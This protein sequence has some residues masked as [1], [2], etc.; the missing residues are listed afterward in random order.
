[1][2]NQDN[3]NTLRD[4]DRYIECVPFDDLVVFDEGEEE[5]YIGRTSLNRFIL[6]PSIAGEIVTSLING[7]NL[8]VISEELNQRNIEV[9]L[10][11]YVENLI[12]LNFIKTVDGVEYESELIPKKNGLT[13]KFIKQKHVKWIFSKPI[14]IAYSLFVFIALYLLL[15][16]K[17]GSIIPT[18][19]EAFWHPSLLLVV[20]SVI[21]IDIIFNSSHE[22]FHF[23]S[24]RAISGGL[25][26][27]SIG[28][29][30]THLVFQT[31]I[32][33]I[34]IIPRKQRIIIYLSGILFDIFLISVFVYIAYFQYEN[35]GVLYNFSRFLILLLIIGILF[36][37]RFYMKTD[38]YY[39]VSDYL[40]YPT[41][42]EESYQLVKDSFKFK[43][44]ISLYPKKVIVY[45]F[46]MFLGS[47]IDIW[48][49]FKYIVP[50][51]ISLFNNVRL[52]LISGNT[53]EVI[54]NILTVFIIVLEAGLVIYFFIKEK[55][56]NRVRV[57]NFEP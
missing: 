17:S 12:N 53:A 54:A 20:V 18:A 42:F 52:S 51:A 5:V 40:K 43:N 50:V 15:S 28:R 19:D 44:N 48:L 14:A 46:F 33:N 27:M 13:M 45:T 25:G 7:K 23:F 34:W 8:D 49:V 16:G 38:L 39:V 37:F 31:R 35:Q 21:L 47:V 2:P 57:T 24:T 30:L 10:S 55:S 22:I 3:T 36:E 41:L 1:M 29:R 32:E 56:T 4:V 9:D 6:V 26:Y 11:D